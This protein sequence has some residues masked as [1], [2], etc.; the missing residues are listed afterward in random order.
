MMHVYMLLQNLKKVCNF[1]ILGHWFIWIYQLHCT[2][3]FLLKVADE[4]LIL[5]HTIFWYHLNKAMSKFFNKHQY[6]YTVYLRAIYYYKNKN[7]LIYLWNRIIDSSNL[8]IVFMLLQTISVPVSFLFKLI[9][10]TSIKF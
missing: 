1:C 5:G 2:V 3:L 6:L 4:L 8:T 9:R 10:Y 7:T